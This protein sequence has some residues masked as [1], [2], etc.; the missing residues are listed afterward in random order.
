[1]KNKDLSAYGGDTIKGTTSYIDIKGVYCEYY[2]PMK[3]IRTY[4]LTK[5]EKLAQDL[6]VR[7]MTQ[8]TESFVSDATI[9][10]E[11]QNAFKCAEVFFDQLEQYNKDNSVSL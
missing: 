3:E 1:M 5:F 10:L 9:K 4:G 6:F 7:Q 2:D 8:H 11:A